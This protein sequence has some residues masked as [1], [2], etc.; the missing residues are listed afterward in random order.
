MRIFKNKEL[1][2]NTLQC[3]ANGHLFD[4]EW[5]YV[6]NDVVNYDM[7]LDITIKSVFTN[8]RGIG[9]EVDWAYSAFSKMY[10]TFIT[11]YNRKKKFRRKAYR[12]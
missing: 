8:P 6:Y 3:L 7:D 10:H 5:Q 12:I 1:C 4:A 11:N 9:N 2:K